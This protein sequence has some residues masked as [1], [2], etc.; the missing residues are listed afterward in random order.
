MRTHTLHTHHKVLQSVLKW[1]GPFSLQRPVG[2]VR[3]VSPNGPVGHRKLKWCETAST[4]Q[5]VILPS[6]NGALTKTSGP[7]VKIFA[8]G[9]QRNILPPPPPGMGSLT[10]VWGT[11]PPTL[12]NFL[13][14][15]LYFIRDMLCSLTC[16]TAD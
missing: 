16:Y 8:Y 13:Q 3:P 7:V 5:L 15:C 4:E 10:D 2:P 1:S 12:R 9:S 11:P 6:R 14:H